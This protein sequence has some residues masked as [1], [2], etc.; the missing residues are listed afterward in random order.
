MFASFLLLVLYICRTN[1]NLITSTRTP[2]A[3]QLERVSI[4]N[5]STADS[6]S[7]KVYETAK[8]PSRTKALLFKEALG[9]RPGKA[10]KFDMSRWRLL[11]NCGLYKD[12]SAKTVSKDGEVTLVVSGQELPSITFSPEVQLGASLDNP[13]VAGGVV[14]KDRNFRGI[15]EQFELVVSAFKEG[16][17]KGVASLP[18]SFN[19]KWIDGI[20][21]RPDSVTIAWDEEYDMHSAK[22]L[23]SEQNPTD[24]L[25]VMQRNVKVT[26]AGARTLSESAGSFLSGSGFKY[27]LEPFQCEIK[28]LSEEHSD[29]SSSLSGAKFKATHFPKPSLNNWPAVTYK[30]EVGVNRRGGWGG[31]KRRYQTLG[32]EVISPNLVLHEHIDVPGNATH[33]PEGLQAYLKLK[34][35]SFASR[36]PGR[37]PMK[38][39]AN[40]ADPKYVRGFDMDTSYT[41]TES[42]GEKGDGSSMSAYSVVRGDV[43]F[44]GIVPWGIPG[45]FVDTAVFRKANGGKDGSINKWGITNPI[46]LQGHV[47]SGVSLRAAGFRVD[48]GWPVGRKIR[49]KLYVGLDGD[50]Y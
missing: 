31:A 45:L 32:V 37:V 9:L 25:Q 17:E 38:H 26:M 36:G 13:E 8:D 4:K 6:R 34:W 43:G 47:T 50:D 24:K 41:F 39:F 10:F 44:N 7:D 18:P 29:K 22:E 16:V 14:L 27:S 42:S 28:P 30:H 11:Q 49:P 20:A 15:G 48:V 12:L 1:A 35:S 2:V 23:G 40:F 33:K 5:N 46:G 3:L 19:V 21:G